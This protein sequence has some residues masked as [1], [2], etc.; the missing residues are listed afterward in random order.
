[1]ALPP[2]CSQIAQAFD[3][4]GRSFYNA[5]MSSRDPLRVFDKRT[6]AR[7]IRGGRVSEDDYGRFLGELPDLGEHIRRSDDGGDD[8]GFDDRPPRRPL[9]SFPSGG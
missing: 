8:D 2:R 1:M 4:S 3:A 6:V 7:N 9:V 5:A